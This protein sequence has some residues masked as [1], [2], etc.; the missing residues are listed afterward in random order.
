VTCHVPDQGDHQGR[1]PVWG[2]GMPDPM[3]GAPSSILLIADP[4]A[5]VV[6][7]E[8]LSDSLPS[9]LTDCAA[10]DGKWD[11][12]VRRDSYRVDGHAEVLAKER[13]PILTLAGNDDVQPVAGLAFSEYGVPAWK[14]DGLELFGQRRD[15]AAF[16]WR[17]RGKLS[18]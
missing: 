1:F 10:A 18:G 5:P 11:V 13:W 15:R 14:V 9:A 2:T 12:S 6:I 16:V 7:A 17:L 3:A 4:G 8:R